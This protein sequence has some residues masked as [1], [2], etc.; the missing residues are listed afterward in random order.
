MKKTEL[1]VGDH[2]LARGKN[3]R[4]G[5]FSATSG[6]VDVID[7]DEIHFYSIEQLEPIPLTAEMLEKNG[8]IHRQSDKLGDFFTYKWFIEQQDKTLQ[9]DHY[10]KLSADPYEGT[11]FY[12]V[13]EMSAVAALLIHYVHELQHLL[14]L[15]GIGKEMTL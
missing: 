2:V 13:P 9:Y 15:C 1:M 11:G 4:I 14:H 8:F 12:W 5:G 10:F 3:V 7:N 6:W